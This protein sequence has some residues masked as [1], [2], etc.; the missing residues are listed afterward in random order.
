[1]GEGVEVTVGSA[2]VEVEVGAAVGVAGGG[3]GWAVQ[4]K[5]KRKTATNRNQRCMGHLLAIILERLGGEA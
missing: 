1:M 4:P 3:V 2:G 5:L